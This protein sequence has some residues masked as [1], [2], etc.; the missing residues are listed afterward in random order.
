MGQISGVNAS[1]ITSIAGIAVANISYV[2]PVS[3]ATLGLG[4]GGGGKLFADA[5]FGDGGTACA[6]GPVAI[7]KGRTQTL[8]TSGEGFYTDSGLTTPFDGGGNWWYDG[9]DNISYQIGNEG[10]FFDVFSCG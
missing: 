10:N 3:A 9:T 7:S 6:D 8:Y 4:G 5:T 1:S 2:G